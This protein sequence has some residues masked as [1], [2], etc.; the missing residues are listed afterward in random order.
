MY[1]FYSLVTAI[2]AI[3]AAPYF[4][5]Q[6]LRRGKHL[7]NLTERF[8]KLPALV[9]ARANSEPGAIW[10]HAVS[11]GETLAALRLV[12]QL[13]E[14]FP[15]RRLVFST[16]TDTGQQLA[17]ERLGA[18]AAV[19]YFPFDW[20]FA[21]RRAFRAVR[22]SVVVILETEIWPNF[23]RVAS[24][25]RIP[26]VF[27]NGRLSE[28]S[29][30]RYRRS[31]AWIGF[32]LK[33]FLRRVF[34][35]ASL[36]LMQSKEDA[37][38]LLSLGAPVE[39]VH[40]SGNLKYDQELASSSALTDWLEAEV[41]RGERRPLVVAGSV[42]AHEEPLILIAFGILQGEWRRA[43]LVLAPRKPERFEAAADFINESHRKFIRRSA[44][45]AQASAGAK[46]REPGGPDQPGLKS[47]LPD[48][49]S[50][51][52]LDSVGELAGLYRA[53]DAVFVGGSLV[54]SG[55]HNI[56][57][58]AAFAKVP[59]FGPSMENF[60]E[61]A[62]NFLAAGAAIQVDSPEDLGVAWIELVK[63]AARRE[64]MGSAAKHLVESSRGATARALE[65]ISRFLAQPDPSGP[66]PLAEHANP[67]GASQG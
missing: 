34:S 8:G 20:G 53:A 24:S 35:T 11:V 31:F 63:D 50:V 37:G 61:V 36:F 51:V 64:Q 58:P 13:K 9:P 60:K 62:A 22:P 52:L 40:V 57:E 59:V 48:D 15:D 5:I 33:P 25:S 38:R 10:I 12:Q 29:F 47:V 17:R 39:K 67:V 32:F 28:R 54:P 16:T 14:R 6:G 46:E 55:G 56:L 26:V 2:G 7:H 49:A 30:R 27:V 21:V 19:F 45:L 4:L 43:L 3:L 18:A 42:V 23:L 41:R 65:S 1:F 44:L 66:I